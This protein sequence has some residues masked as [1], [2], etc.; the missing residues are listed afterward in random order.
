M[1][2]QYITDVLYTLCGRK[3]TCVYLPLFDDSC[4]VGAG[5]M[6]ERFAET[7]ITVAVALYLAMC[8]A[9]IVLLLCTH[10]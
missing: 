7:T 9:I 8:C 5:L 10:T 3:A 6:R 2:R 4:A 1:M